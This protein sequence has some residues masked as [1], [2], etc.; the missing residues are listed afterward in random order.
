MLTR[1]YLSPSSPV[2][3]ASSAPARDGSPD[4]VVSEIF[5][6]PRVVDRRAFSE[7]SA[8]LREIVERAAIE[9]A[10]MVA[11]LDQAGTSLQELRSREQSQQMNLEL[12]L[13]ALK[14]IEE[15]SGKVEDLLGRAAETSKL[16]E[17][18]D[19]QADALMNGKLASMEARLDAL[20]AGATAKA[21]ALEE[22]IRRAGKELEQRVEAIRRDAQQIAAPVQDGLLAL[23][24]RATVL[25]STQPGRGGLGELITR[26]EQ[27]RHDAERAVR[28][29]DAA[30]ERSQ[31]ARGTTET[32][33][34]ET[35][36]RLDAISKQRAAVDAETQSNA[37][38]LERSLE[39]IRATA[40]ATQTEAAN[41]AQQS[42]DA[43]RQ[44]MTQ[45][46]RSL[47]SLRDQAGSSRLDA[48]LRMRQAIET[49]Q[50]S[51]AELE[52]R[53]ASAR[54][55]AEASFDELAP[56]AEIAAAAL[57]ET[58]KQSQDAH[59]TTALAMRVL[60]RSQAQM[61][62]LMAKLE[63]WKSMLEEGA[64]TVPAPVRKMLESV[65]A[66]LAGVAGALRGAAERV[67]RAGAD[68]IA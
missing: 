68:P 58:I 50:K 15:K 32:W 39:T 66:D 11:A 63:P 33:I 19:A 21:E 23:C 46:E 45:F 35:Q 49:A 12:A 54:R 20:S 27:L 57:R 47:E 7:L 31:I 38:Q 16:F 30:H 10:A 41:H 9:R 44:I 62:A 3:T 40:R 48:E 26:G 52:A 4:V 18:L 42:I 55:A 37:A 53:A 36:A 5:L 34:G 8:E 14:T 56:R 17:A 1:P 22:R 24:E 61:Q 43:A 13:R 25:A 2:A 67:D 65:R 28:E 6:S 64:D 59:N 29:L 51:I 60:D